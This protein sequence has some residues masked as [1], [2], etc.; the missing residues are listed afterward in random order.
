MSR[1]SRGDA[2][3]AV[4]LA[5]GTLTILP[6]R[7]P[8]RVDRSVAGRAMTLAPV[9][10]TALGLLGLLLV[11][12]LRLVL[13]PL[14][15]AVL[16]VV[17]IGLATRLIHW[18]GLADTSDGL[19]SGQPAAAALEIMRRS[20]IGP[21]GVFATVSAFAAQVAALATLV[22]QDAVAA[23]LVATVLGRA[24]LLVGCRV[25]VPAARR[26][27]LGPAVAGSVGYVQMAV[28]AAFTVVV[29]VVATLLNHHL[30]WPAGLLATAVTALWALGT[31]WYLPRRFGGMT[32]DTMGALVESSTTVAL[33]L[34]AAA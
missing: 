13:D 29:V 32:G 1:V 2:L 10:G 7:P 23:V 26:N 25:G 14:L 33:V 18:D 16:V 19:G 11:L 24:A 3:D 20:D 21:F 9:V 27:G 15:V 30:G 28:G 22:A 31:T 12:L 34:L 17:A 5:F 6:V 8:G 4:R